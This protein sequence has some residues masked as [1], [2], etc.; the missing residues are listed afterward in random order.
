MFRASLAF[1]STSRIVTPSRFKLPI[2]PKICLVTSGAN[3]SDGSSRRSTLGLAINARPMASICCSPPLSVPAGC[4]SRSFRMGKCPYTR[5]KSPGTFCLSRREYV[6]I[7]RFSRT[8]SSGNTC[9]PSGA[10]TTPRPTMC[11]G[12]SMSMP[13]P[14]SSMLPAEGRTTPDI[15]LRV[16]VLPAPLEPRSATTSPSRTSSDTPVSALIRPYDTSMLR[17]LS[18]ASPPLPDTPGSPGD[19]AAP[20]RACP[21]RSCCRSSSP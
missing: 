14:I 17:T 11:S 18:T 3:P 19:C 16:V 5:L 20:R 12:A 6:P 21:R 15:A 9:L 2:I 1:C 4:F 10:C 8:D 13:L 7:S